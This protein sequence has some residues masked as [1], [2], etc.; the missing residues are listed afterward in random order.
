M[1]FTTSLEPSATGESAIPPETDLLV[2]GGGPAGLAT[3]IAAR[4]RGLEVVVAD[5][6]RA[7]IDKPCGEGLLPDAVQALRR[8]GVMIGASDGLV[9]RGI[10]FHEDG[11]TVGAEFRNGIGFGV[12]RS[13]LHQRMVQRAQECGVSFAWSSAV[14]GLWE[15][16]VIIGRNKVRAR[17]VIGADGINSLVMSRYTL[18][19]YRRKR[20]AWR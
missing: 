5:G 7:P 9:L 11:R 18:R 19:P 3:A 4:G 14:T 12:R 17:W 1:A 2:V 6:R 10:R 15:Q 16:G 20:S 13:V 8:L